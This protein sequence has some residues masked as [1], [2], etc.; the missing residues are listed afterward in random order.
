[1]Y[2]KS[3]GGVWNVGE[4]ATGQEGVHIM[5]MNTLAVSLINLTKIYF[6]FM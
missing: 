4:C 2:P 5:I 3:Y 6:W 1:M